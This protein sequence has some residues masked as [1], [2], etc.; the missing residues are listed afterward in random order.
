M[1]RQKIVFFALLVVCVFWWLSVVNRPPSFP[2]ATPTGATLGISIAPKAYEPEL[3]LA[4]WRAEIAY[5]AHRLDEVSDLYEGLRQRIVVSANTNL[6]PC[7]VFAHPIAILPAPN[8]PGKKG[9]PTVRTFTLRAFN[10]PTRPPSAEGF[11]PFHPDEEQSSG[12]DSV[13]EVKKTVRLPWSSVFTFEP[14]DAS[15][16]TS[17]YTSTARTL[18]LW[19]EKR[20]QRGRGYRAEYGITLVTNEAYASTLYAEV[21]A[22][23]EMVLVAAKTFHAEPP[24]CI[25]MSSASG[26]REASAIGNG[27]S[28]AMA[29][30]VSWVYMNCDNRDKYV[31]HQPVPANGVQEDWRGNFPPCNAN[32]RFARVPFQIRVNATNAMIHLEWSSD[33]HGIFPGVPLT[34]K[35]DNQGLFGVEAAS[36]HTKNDKISP[37][38]L[39]DFIGVSGID[40]PEPPVTPDGLQLPLMTELIHLAP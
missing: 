37:S 30:L 33:L 24:K 4:Q 1:K 16:D 20:D 34:G 31:F 13:F 39:S 8:E 3:L 18:V 36:L 5:Y 2:P 35:T 25:Q 26:K 14:L 9:E 19:S 40:T 27:F 11:S 23:P 21:Y 38:R 28:E 29:D 12:S 17:L 6:P 22:V 7:A 32:G 10:T 15:V